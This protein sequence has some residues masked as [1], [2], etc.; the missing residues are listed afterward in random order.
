MNLIVTLMFQYL[1]LK[2][3]SDHFPVFLCAAASR[4]KTGCNIILKGNDPYMVVPISHLE[5]KKTTPGRA[6]GN[7][8]L[9]TLD[10]DFTSQAGCPSNTFF[11]YL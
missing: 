5:K 6:A 7:G 8:L 1:H 9:R 3:N 11:I 10:L 4:S 2:G